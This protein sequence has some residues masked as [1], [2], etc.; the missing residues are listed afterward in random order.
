METPVNLRWSHCF[1]GVMIITLVFGLSLTSMITSQYSDYYLETYMFPNT[2]DPNMENVSTCNMNKSTEKYR[3]KTEVQKAAS[4][5]DIYAS[6]SETGPALITLAIMGTLSDRFG[7]NKILM[8]NISF[9]LAAFCLSSAIIYFEINVYYFLIS[10]TLYS[11]GGG[12]FGA[13]SIGF[14]YIS[15][16]TDSGKQR[17]LLIA[18]LEALIGVS[19]AVSD[20]ASGYM[21]ERIGFFYSNLCACAAAVTSVLVVALLL[22]NSLPSD[23]D[24]S[25]HTVCEHISASFAF[26]F[27]PSPK[28]YKYVLTIT[29]F[30]VASLSIL[31]KSPVEMVVGVTIM[32]VLQIFFVDE[33]IAI[34][35][36][37]SGMAS[38][39]VEAFAVDDATLFAASVIGCPFQVGIAVVEIATS[40]GSNAGASAI[41]MATVDT[42]R[43]FVF[44]VFA[45]LSFLAIIMLLIYRITA[46]GAKTV[47]I[48]D[49]TK[50]INC[51][52]VVAED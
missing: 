35:G 44:L 13:L 3:E 37:I 31:G 28:R 10:G 32:K 22:P 36:G 7:R 43:G 41:Y 15:D 46:G 6:V 52:Q 12:L 30:M 47:P 18:L 38:S 45:G 33:V 8:I 51:T 23:M 1:I 48:P 39:I 9:C 19:G 24:S 17:T 29:L 50:E 26:Y 2:T 16:I 21:I 42:L 27:K 14:A 20:I 49:M 34:L 25:H 5:L 40:L 4:Q 11:I